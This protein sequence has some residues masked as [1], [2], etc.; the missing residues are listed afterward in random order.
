MRSPM[1]TLSLRFTDQDSL[2]VSVLDRKP[3]NDNFA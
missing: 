2:K 1:M 3:G